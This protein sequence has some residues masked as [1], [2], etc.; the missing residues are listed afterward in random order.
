MRKILSTDIPN[1]IGRDA[2]KEAK[3]KSIVDPADVS[4][5]V[6]PESWLRDGRENN[7]VSPVLVGSIILSHDTDN[8]SDEAKDAHFEGDKREE[9]GGR[10]KTKIQGNP[11]IWGSLSAVQ[12][13]VMGT[14][15]KP[16]LIVGAGGRQ[17]AMASEWLTGFLR[18]CRAALSKAHERLS[19]ES[20]DAEK[21][22]AAL[23]PK[24]GTAKDAAKLQ[25]K[26]EAAQKRLLYFDGKDL[27]SR[28]FFS[29]FEALRDHEP[30]LW[31]D[32][33]VE[34]KRTDGLFTVTTPYRKV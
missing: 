4:F 22:V 23:L 11:V 19:K 29:I 25:E 6:G 9:G 31:E 2:K 12:I 18:R 5:A 16:V 26:L 14:D 20:A 27:L 34:N 21:E 33:T 30:I 1:S 8:R 13:T 24:I 7:P 32:Y 17:T 3:S 15:E 28:C 10:K